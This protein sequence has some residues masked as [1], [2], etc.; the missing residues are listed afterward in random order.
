MMAYMGQH[1]GIMPMLNMH[2][3]NLGKTLS[4]GSLGRGPD[5]FL[6]WRVQIVAKCF[7]LLPKNNNTKIN[8]N[9]NLMV[10]KA[11]LKTMREWVQQ[12]LY[13]EVKIISNKNVELRM[14]KDIYWKFLVQGFWN[15][16]PNASKR[17]N[18]SIY[19]DPSCWR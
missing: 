10:D 4:L 11:D 6:A 2:R 8:K 5:V 19:G 18:K 3:V 16:G 13:L 17:D 9:D 1:K 12:K 7:K 14:G 15:I